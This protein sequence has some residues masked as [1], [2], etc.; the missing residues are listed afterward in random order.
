MDLCFFF[1]YVKD[2]HGYPL[3]QPPS[4]PQAD[5]ADNLSPYYIPVSKK[6]KKQ[7]GKNPLKHP[8]NL[9][10]AQQNSFEVLGNLDPFK[11]PLESHAPLTQ[12]PP[13]QSQP[14]NPS[15]V[16]IPSLDHPQT[17]KQPQIP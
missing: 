9:I 8:S 4:Q 7:K 12:D 14:S 17:E 1:F 16:S 10:P 3:N 15:I 13:R 11:N 5:K 2:I 6:S